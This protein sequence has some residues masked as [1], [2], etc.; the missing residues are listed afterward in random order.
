MIRAYNS[1]KLILLLYRNKTVQPW[2][3]PIFLSLRPIGKDHHITLLVFLVKGSFTKGGG[4]E[5]PYPKPHPS[6]ET[7]S[8]K[9]TWPKLFSKFV[10]HLQL[11][12]DSGGLTFKECKIKAHSLILL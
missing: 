6:W 8:V 10:L 11:R 9:K 1:R 7:L 2:W 4:C 3:H 12:S 5:P